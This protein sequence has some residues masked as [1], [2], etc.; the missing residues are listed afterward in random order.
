MTTF[1]SEYSLVLVLATA[2]GSLSAAVAQATPKSES[3]T[4]K[5]GD[6]LWSISRVL[7]GDPFLWPQIFRLNT[8]TVQDPHW[9]YPGQELALVP[10]AGAQAVPSQET[11]PPAKAE[12]VE[13]P[14]T[15]DK[16]R[17]VPEIPAPEQARPAEG[18]SLF[19]RRHG[20]DARSALRSYREQPYRPL[21]KGEFWSAGFLTEEAELSFGKVVGTVTPQQ[22]RNVSE[23]ATASLYSTVAVL[24]PKEAQYQTGDTLLLAQLEAGFPG[25]GH[26]VVPTGL[27]RVTGVSGRQ[28]LVEVV[29]VYGPIRNGQL[30]LPAEKFVEGGNTRAQPVTNGVTGHLL[31]GREIRELKQQQNIM[32]IDVGQKD[33]VARGDIFE[34]RR[35]P[36]PRLGAADTI[37]ELMATLQV[38]HVGEHSATVKV[39]NVV[40]PDIAPGVVVKQV[41]KL[42]S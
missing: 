16:P 29:A 40:S 5:A 37:D 3:Y 38:L 8:Q 10:R 1:R 12:P 25:Y 19:A 41:A 7:L 39:L 34:V 18:D 21:R 32:F 23:R 36:G 13:L 27:A 22:I 28:T 15:P 33:G 6:T 26:M 42:P 2:A 30:A 11:P 20:V 17:V 24:P 4:V 14:R 35:T 9:I 31:G